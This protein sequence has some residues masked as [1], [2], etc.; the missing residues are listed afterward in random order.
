[1]EEKGYLGVYNRRR[2]K[3]ERQGWRRQKRPREQKWK[4]YGGRGGKYKEKTRK[5][6]K[7]LRSNKRHK[8][9]S[10]RAHK[11]WIWRKI[12]VFISCQ[13]LYCSENCKCKKHASFWQ[14]CLES[15]I[16]TLATNSQASKL[17]T[18]TYFLFTLPI[19][20]LQFEQKRNSLSCIWSRLQQSVKLNP[21]IAAH[22]ASHG[23]RTAPK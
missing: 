13:Y 21:I 4:D 7:G 3:R 18:E 14:L 5:E 8:R 20:H 2:G 9:N 1:V 17:F 12:T 6:E 10:W 19:N 23:H 15:I 22:T 11:E 16:F